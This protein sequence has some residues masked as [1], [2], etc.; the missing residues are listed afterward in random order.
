MSPRASTLAFALALGLGCPS[1]AWS[2]P[3]S[4]AAPNLATGAAVEEDDS[5]DSAAGSCAYRRSSDGG[6]SESAA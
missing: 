1:L 4:Q 2:Q 5:G 3:Q 6:A